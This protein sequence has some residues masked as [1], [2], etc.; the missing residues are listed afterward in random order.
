GEEIIIAR[1]HEPVARLVRLPRPDAFSAVIAEV[2]AARA[3]R[4]A[5][6][7][8]ELMAWRDEGRR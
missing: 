2:K 7:P 4:A 3:G 8:E 6:R 1:G 5:T